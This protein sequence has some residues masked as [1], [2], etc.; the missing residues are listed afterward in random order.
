M[1]PIG[2]G[3][4]GCGGIGRIHLD[5]YRKLENARVVAVC[6]VDTGALG[7]A[8]AEHGVKRAFEDY[9]AL[10]DRKDVDAVSVCLPNYLHC[11]VTVDA[12][13]AWKHVLCE[14]PAAT[15][16][17]EAIRMIEAGE[18]AGKQLL[19]GLCQRFHGGSQVLKAHIES[20]ELGEIYYAKCGYLRRSGIPGMGGW[21]TTQ[22]QAGA[23]P[24]YDIGVHALDL[25]LWLMDNFEPES[26]LAA[27]FAKFGPLGKGAGGWATPVPG[28]PFDVE[29]LAAAL[30]RMKNGA[31]IS[32]E[33]SWA[34]HVGA[35]AFSSTLLGD[36]AGADFGSMTIFSEEHGNFVD[37]KLAFEEK[38][39]YLEEM[40]HFLACVAGEEQPLTTKAQI[41]GAQK[42]LDAILH[43][44]KTGASVT[45]V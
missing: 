20:G 8:K 21:F 12:F 15:S 10:L 31:A 45:I 44:A 16:T 33:V 43:S 40:R 23:G 34:A 38:D 35:G 28:G 37:K 13:A 11:P 1:D 41:I 26:A 5:A 14:K 25:T 18:Q 27:S 19:I 17:D 22:A 30:I 6:D 2:I 9:R 32:F 36:R 7:R 24:I 29:D 4:I 3:V 39:T 42:T